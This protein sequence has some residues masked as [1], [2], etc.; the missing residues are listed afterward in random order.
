MTRMLIALTAAAAASAAWG[1]DNESQPKNRL[2]WKLEQ[3]A[4]LRMSWKTKLLQN[5]SIGGKPLP[6]TDSILVIRATLTVAETPE[7]GPAVCDLKIGSYELKGIYQGSEVDVLFEEGEFKSA[8]GLLNSAEVKK[9]MEPPL[10][11]TLSPQGEFKAQ[12]QTRLA[13]IFSGDGIWFGP[14]LPTKSVLVGDTWE[15]TLQTPQSKARGGPSFTVHR[16]LESVDT[17]VARIVTD[18]EKE[19]EQMGIKM[20][21]RITSADS[22]S[23]GKGYFVKSKSTV[24]AGGS[25]EVQG[26]EVV[27]SAE[28]TIE[29]EVTKDTND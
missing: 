7:E 4:V 21:F 15:E 14:R 6:K 20:K 12:D 22:F 1:Q 26:Q 8:K 23:M 19:F 25:G 28:S 10:R 2:A 11:L 24:A 16:K 5:S 9:A 18:E 3:G 13:Q 17:G 29:L 27:I